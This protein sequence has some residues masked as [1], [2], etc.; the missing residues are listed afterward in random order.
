[1]SENVRKFY[2][3]EFNLQIPNI[4]SNG[5]CKENM[6]NKAT[7]YLEVVAVVNYITCAIDLYVVAAVE[8]NQWL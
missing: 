1:M 4:L 8:S 6:P 5:F 2:H 3:N 7:N